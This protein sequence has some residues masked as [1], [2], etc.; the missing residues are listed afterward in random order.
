MPPPR[1]T[2][3]GARRERRS[4]ASTV[5]R[6]GRRHH[7]ALL[8]ARAR[9]MPPR[10]VLRLLCAGLLLTA[11]RTNTLAEQILRDGQF[12]SNL[13]QLND[14]YSW[15]GLDWRVGALDYCPAPATRG[16]V[17]TSM[18]AELG[19]P[20]LYQRGH[21]AGV[22]SFECLAQVSRSYPNDTAAFILTIYDG[23]GEI[24]QQVAEMPSAFRDEWCVKITCGSNIPRPLHME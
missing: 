17:V 24:I 6:H 7:H 19:W 18:Y 3:R 9:P 22:Y 4:T 8:C 21:G 11:R 23:T 5:R 16:L 1:P 15:S 13:T 12:A 10:A 14:V 2:P 20:G